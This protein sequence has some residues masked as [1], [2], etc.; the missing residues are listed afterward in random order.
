MQR[1]RCAVLDTHPGC[2]DF[3]QPYCWQAMHQGLQPCI[4]ANGL[5]QTK[6]NIVRMIKP[7]YS[8]FYLNIFSEN[9]P[10]PRSP[11]KE[12]HSANELHH[13]CEP[14]VHKI[15]SFDTVQEASR[16]WIEM[17]FNKF[18]DT[19]HWFKDRLIK[20]RHYVNYSSRGTMQ[21]V[22][23]A[24]R[25]TIGSFLP[26]ENH[27][28]VFHQILQTGPPSLSVPPGLPEPNDVSMAWLCHRSYEAMTEVR[29]RLY[30]GHSYDQ[31]TKTY[32]VRPGD[33]LRSQ[34]KTLIQ[35][36]SKT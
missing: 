2:V 34:R 20:R 28:E 1:V 15:A 11:W 3:E 23:C 9:D 31:P 22:R 12:M 24:V 26:Q 16:I 27:R 29:P 21:R 30:R 17:K 6:Q 33:Y 25:K 13:F 35:L 10:N 7:C 32:P 14:V 19:F 8:W 36:S 4:R 18:T 5:K